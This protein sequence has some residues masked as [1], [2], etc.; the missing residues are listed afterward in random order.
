MGMCSSI[1]ICEQRSQ[2]VAFFFFFPFWVID[3]ELCGSRIV[4]RKKYVRPTYVLLTLLNI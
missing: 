4:K 3:V 2:Y 1:H